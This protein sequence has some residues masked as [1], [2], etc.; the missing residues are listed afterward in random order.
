MT[1]NAFMITSTP[2]AMRSSALT[3][4]K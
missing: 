4:E 3:Q 2:V 1:K